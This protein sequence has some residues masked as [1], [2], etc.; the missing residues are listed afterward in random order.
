V[1]GA[2]AGSKLLTPTG[3][4]MTAEM[5]PQFE[6]AIPE[7]GDRT[8]DAGKRPYMEALAGMW[9][10]RFDD[11]YKAIKRAHGEGSL[12]FSM[13]AIPP[14]VTCPESGC[15]KTAEFIGL[16]DEASPGAYC[17]HINGPILPKV[18]DKPNF[19]GG[20]IIIPPVRPG[21]KKA[22]ITAISKLAQEHADTAEGVYLAAKNLAPHLGE[23]A[24]ETVMAMVLQ[25]AELE[26]A[27]DAS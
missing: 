24:W 13:E 11:E 1:V 12:F 4:T 26:G 3:E 25:G 17:A 9:H 15:G 5:I 16:T 20:A 6:A 19:V 18:L 10:T 21:W 14:T 22:D 7:L 8:A 23:S 2:F 27:H